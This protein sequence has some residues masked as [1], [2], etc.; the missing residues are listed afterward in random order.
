MLLDGQKR[1]AD[2][3]GS[4]RGQ[5]ES[6]CCAFSGEEFVRDLNQNSGAVS[7]FGIASAGSAVGEADQDLNSLLDNLVTLVT[8]DAGDEAH[9][10]GVVLVS[11]VVQPLC[12]G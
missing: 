6:Q 8:G 7:S 1:H 11:R 9:A 5:R 4:G 2:S 3:V 10:A 12:R